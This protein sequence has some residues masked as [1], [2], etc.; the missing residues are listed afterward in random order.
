MTFRE[1]TLMLHGSN[2]RDRS[3]MKTDRTPD[4]LHLE[5]EEA[6]R[7]IA[8]LHRLQE[9]LRMAKEQASRAAVLKDAFLSTISHEIRT[10]MNVILGFTDIFEQ[11][12]GE[13][14]DPEDDFFFSSIRDASQRLLRTLDL[15]VN[16]S[17]AASGNYKGVF[18]EYDIIE[19]LERLVHQFAPAAHERHLCLEFR[20]S[21]NTALVRIDRYAF[22]QSMQNLLDNAIR[23]THD[24][25]VFVTV[26]RREH[27]VCIE[28]L[29]TGEGMSQEFL[30]RIFEPFNQEDIG[31]SRQYDGVGLGLA[32][33]KRYIELCHGSIAVQSQKGKGTRFTV[34][35]PLAA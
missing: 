27:S 1:S 23:F 30:S 21:E 6:N 20:P 19:G 14:L 9:E 13:M 31:L 5:L 18:E 11:R 10:P 8:E 17:C 26:R 32:L 7:T 3:G 28:V 12:Y 29:D 33:T 2:E 25:G 24:G 15:M 35:L 16:V 4:Q 34:C 22:E